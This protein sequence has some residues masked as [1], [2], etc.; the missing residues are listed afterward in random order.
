MLRQRSVFFQTIFE[1]A[2]VQNANQP[3][4]LSCEVTQGQQSFT[5]HFFPKA[6]KEK[7][8]WCTGEQTGADNMRNSLHTPEGK[9]SIL[10]KYL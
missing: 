9:E 1:M 8:P 5:K 2:R 4:A 6:L 3:Q 10:I 7:K